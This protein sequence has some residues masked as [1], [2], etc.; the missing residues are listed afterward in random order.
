MADQAEQS[1]AGFSRSE[2]IAAFSRVLSAD[3]ALAE[4]DRLLAVVGA[5]RGSMNGYSLSPN[6]WALLALVSESCAAR[7][8]ALTAN[9][10]APMRERIAALIAEYR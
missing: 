6:T 7:V 1:W 8:D 2:W 9:Y 4:A 3:E 5:E 10:P